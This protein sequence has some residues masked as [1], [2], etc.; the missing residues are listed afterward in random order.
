MK[1]NKPVD[2][3]MCQVVSRRAKEQTAASTSLMGRFET[4]IGSIKESEFI[5]ESAG[6]MG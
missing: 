4:E 1:L 5:N 6:C 3:A 2:P